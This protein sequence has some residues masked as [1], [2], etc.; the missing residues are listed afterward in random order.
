MQ[1]NMYAIAVAGVEELFPVRPCV[2][3][4]K[5]EALERQLYSRIIK[6]RWAIL[7]VK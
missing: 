2:R 7:L 4:C 6:A 5:Q 1:N 3:P